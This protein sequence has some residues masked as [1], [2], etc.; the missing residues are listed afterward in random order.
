MIDKI[1]RNKREKS[2]RPPI[3][4][5]RS[6]RKTI[7]VEYYASIFSNGSA[8]YD[9]K[10]YSYFIRFIISVARIFNRKAVGHHIFRDFC[11]LGVLLAR[12]ISIVFCVCIWLSQ[13][14][15]WVSTHSSTIFPAF[16]LPSSIRLWL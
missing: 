3:Y 10:L 15:I 12:G 4:D 9:Y 1:K 8:Y 5:S 11:T 13:L 7:I 2:V 6:K 16:R 14:A